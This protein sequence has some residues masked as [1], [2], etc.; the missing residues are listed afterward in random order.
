M[1]P[2]TEAGFASWW[3][4]FSQNQTSKRKNDEQQYGQTQT[5]D[6]ARPCEA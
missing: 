6:L 4:T 1:F 3:Q 2:D 5:I